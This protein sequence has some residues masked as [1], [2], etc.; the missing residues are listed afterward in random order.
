MEADGVTKLKDAFVTLWL[1]T[2]PGAIEVVDEAA[3]PAEFKRVT[4]KMPL[5]Q[6]PPGLS[7]PRA[8]PRHRPRGAP[9]PLE[10]NRGI[11]AGGGP[12]PV[13]LFADSLVSLSHCAG[14]CKLAA[15]SRHRVLAPP[16]GRQGTPFRDSTEVKT[17]P[18]CLALA[19]GNSE[20][21]ADLTRLGRSAR[22][23]N[24]RPREDSR[25]R[26]ERN[27]RPSC[28]RASALQGC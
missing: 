12:P 17:A 25:P 14:N 3:V 6:V 2:S 8:E 28:N 5:S 9:R 19:C 1:Q 15:S 27:D 20:T 16:C 7:R 13:A 22:R 18:R 24:G 23:S 21:G 4:L 10:K 11:T 26:H